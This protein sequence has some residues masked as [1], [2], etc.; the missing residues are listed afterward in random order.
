MRV[1]KE[2]PCK[3]WDDFKSKYSK[4]KNKKDYIYRGQNDANWILETSLQ[5]FFK[6][7][8]I[9]IPFPLGG[10]NPIDELLNKYKKLINTTEKNHKYQIN[11][12]FWGIGQHYGLPTPFLDWTKTIY[13]AAFFAFS[14]EVLQTNTHTNVAVYA[15]Q[16]K[17]VHDLGGNSNLQNVIKSNGGIKIFEPYG[18]KLV[19]PNE[20]LDNFRIDAQDGLFTHVDGVNNLSLDLVDFFNKKIYDVYRM[21]KPIILKFIIPRSEYKNALSDLYSMA[22]IDFIGIYPDREGCAKQA[23]LETILDL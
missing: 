20:K 19:N 6:K 16:I 4:V 14:D 7:A 9:L 5:R 17:N 11:D 18:F 8:G 3:S 22:K 13:K 15:L 2:I 21:N 12:D 23:K 10:L 1:V